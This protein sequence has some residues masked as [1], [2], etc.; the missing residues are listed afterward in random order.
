MRLRARRGG[1][2]NVR[3]RGGGS[4]GGGE[5]GW[6]EVV[7]VGVVLEMMRCCLKSVGGGGGGRRVRIG[8]R[9]GCGRGGMERSLGGVGGGVSSS[10]S[11]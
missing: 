4:W 8:C 3:R 1:L 11:E 10:S 6:S 7:V 9:S 2:G 5:A